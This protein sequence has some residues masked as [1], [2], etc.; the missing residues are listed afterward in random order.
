MT[1]ARTSLVTTIADAI[2][3]ELEG[4]EAIVLSR[5]VAGW[6]RGVPAPTRHELEAVCRQIDVRHKVSRAYGE[7]FARLDPEVA[8]PPA[9]VAGVAAALLQY[10]STTEGIGDGLGLKCINSALKAVGM[11]P[12]GAPVPALRAWAVELLDRTL[13]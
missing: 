13:A 4:S 6:L 3:V 11:L 7:G 10:A 2:V 8:A 9:V 12:D 5:H 1:F